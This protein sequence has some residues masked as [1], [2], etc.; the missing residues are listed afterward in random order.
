MAPDTSKAMRWALETEMVKALSLQGYEAVS[1]Y[2]QFGAKTFEGM[3]E[4]QVMNSLKDKT[5]K[6]AMT[7][8]LLDKEKEQHYSPGLIDYSAGLVSNA[9]L[10]KI[11]Y[12]YSKVY[13]PGYYTSST[14]YFV[15]GNLYDVGEDRLIFS[16]QTKTLDPGSL[17]H[18]AKEY[19]KVIVKDMIDKKVISHHMG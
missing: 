7:I 6:A 8:A 10:S 13:A 15:D 14:N 18:L 17:I 4:Q 12:N 2:E 5:I 11:N 9:F 16:V 3:N 1:A 19:S